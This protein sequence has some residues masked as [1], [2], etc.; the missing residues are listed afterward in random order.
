MIFRGHGLAT[1]LKTPTTRRILVNHKDKTPEVNISLNAST[2][3]DAKSAM[4]YIWEKE[5][6]ALGSA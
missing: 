5:E 3:L 4:H 6:D 1:A 2:T